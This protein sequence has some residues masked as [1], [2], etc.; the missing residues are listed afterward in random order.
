ML[1]FNNDA[2]EGAYQINI[3]GESLAP[4]GPEMDVFGNGIPIAGDG[5]NIPAT[6][7]G[8]NFG[9]ITSGTPSTEQ[10]YVIQNNG[11][12]PLTVNPSFFSNPIF[13]ITT[14][15]VSP[16]AAG[17]FTTIGITFNAP[18]AFGITNATLFINN[19][20]TTGGESPYQINV[21][22]ES[23]AA[24]GPEID[25]LGNG[26][27]I[28]GDG[29]NTPNIADDTDFGQITPGT[30]STEHIFTILNTGTSPLTIF[31]SATTD[32][33]FSITTLQTSPVPSGSSTT[34][35]VTY[36]AT[37]TPGNTNA[38]LLIFKYGFK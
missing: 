13:V 10:F 28:I 32:P 37:I 23:V 38:G 24:A 25:V 17:G 31:V 12:T 26:I 21:Q 34:I 19:N 29:S 18:L 9:Q 22:A 27:S 33:I 2:D 8:T 5:T 14:A 20:D 15:A 36:N 35:G 7:D 30:S 1:I 6:A 11:T 16:V 3:K 4:P